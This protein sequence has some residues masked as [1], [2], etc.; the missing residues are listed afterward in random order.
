MLSCFVWIYPFC[1]QMDANWFGVNLHAFGTEETWFASPLKGMISDAR[2]IGINETNIDWEG[3]FLTP[4][5]GAEP[6]WN[7]WTVQIRCN[8]LWHTKVCG[9]TVA[10]RR[11]ADWTSAFAKLKDL[12]G[13]VDTLVMLAMSGHF[14]GALTICNKHVY[15]Y[16]G[17]SWW[18]QELIPT[19]NVFT[20]AGCE[21]LI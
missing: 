21:W 12:T 2:S 11:S 20:K 18:Q 14:I 16:L 3:V 15:F 10:F 19:P 5:S 17:H 13:S 8:V 6:V 7:V 9:F 4:L 1:T